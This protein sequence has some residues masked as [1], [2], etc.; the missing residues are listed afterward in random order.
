MRLP[1]YI[2]SRTWSWKPLACAVLLGAR[3]VQAAIDLDL[4]NPGMRY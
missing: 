4:D 1:S 2:F 3:M